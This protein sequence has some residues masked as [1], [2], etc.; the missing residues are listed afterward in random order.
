MG[1]QIKTAARILRSCRSVAAPKLTKN[2]CKLKSK[3]LINNS[4]SQYIL[5]NKKIKLIKQTYPDCGYVYL[6]EHKD[7]GSPY[8]IKCG[9]TKDRLEQRMKELCKTTNSPNNYIPNQLITAVFVS[10]H[11]QFEKEMHDEFAHY[12]KQGTEW[13]G[14]EGKKKEDR[15]E[16]EKLKNNIMSRIKNK[17]KKCGGVVLKTQ[18]TQD[19]VAAPATPPDN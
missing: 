13:F 16:Y 3:I 15:I 4:I 10:N 1:K 12:R 11:R 9:M 8:F 14:I 5:Q 19:C 17:A 7:P 18:G 6:V 2:K